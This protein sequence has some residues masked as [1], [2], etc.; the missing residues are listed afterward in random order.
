MGLYLSW[1]LNCIQDPM[2]A[3]LNILSKLNYGKYFFPDISQI[4]LFPKAIPNPQEMEIVRNQ[5]AAK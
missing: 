4:Y 5:E 3:A 2:L 1:I